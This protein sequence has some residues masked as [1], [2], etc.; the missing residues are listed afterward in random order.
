MTIND[1]PQPYPIKYKAWSVRR[2]I[3]SN[4]LKKDSKRETVPISFWLKKWRPP[5]TLR[6][7][8]L[9]IRSASSLEISREKWKIMNQS[10]KKTVMTPNRASLRSSTLHSCLSYQLAGKSTTTDTSRATIST[11]CSRSR[12]GRAATRCLVN[13]TWKMTWSCR[14]KRMPLLTMRSLVFHPVAMMTRWKME[15][16]KLNFKRWLRKLR[17]I[18]VK[19][20]SNALM[21]KWKLTQKWRRKNW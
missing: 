13:M 15:L 10:R 1:K 6:Q 16:S 9:T 4:R 5:L 17:Q 7:F 12:P 20:F 11:G 14:W 19:S 2:L 3:W 21:L 8:R 18:R